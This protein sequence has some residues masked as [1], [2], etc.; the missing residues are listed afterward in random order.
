MLQYREKADKELLA[1]KDA[2]KAKGSA[3]QEAMDASNKARVEMRRGAE[4]E[5]RAERKATRGEE[6]RGM[7]AADRRREDSYKKQ[8]QL[9]KRLIKKDEDLLA[10]ER[11]KR[12]KVDAAR[13]EAREATRV[14][15]ARE[16]ELARE[17]QARENDRLKEQE[18][19]QRRDEQRR[20]AARDPH[21][22]PRLVVKYQAQESKL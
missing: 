13:L 7:A 1:A 6:E 11:L 20:E 10:Q 17:S 2:R 9:D 21:V 5:A 15:E 12:A 22:E 4:L 18:L 8:E 14:R 3:D 16:D 19:A